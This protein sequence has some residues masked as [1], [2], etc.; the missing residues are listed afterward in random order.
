MTMEHTP[1][2]SGTYWVIQECWRKYRVKPGE[3]VYWSRRT[4]LS[5]AHAQ[6][7][8]P[9]IS[10]SARLFVLDF[11]IGLFDRRAYSAGGGVEITSF[12]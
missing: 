2:T 9:R 10:P 12:S 11:C 4:S 7:A 3:T 1:D 5:D 6:A 8:N